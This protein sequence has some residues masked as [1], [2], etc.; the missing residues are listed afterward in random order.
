MTDKP[1]SKINMIDVSKQEEKPLSEGI[2]AKIAP[3]QPDDEVYKLKVKR[4][5]PTLWSQE[6]SDRIC[7]EISLGKSLRTVCG[8]DENPKEDMPDIVTILRWLREK[9]EFRTQ[10]E[11]AKEES[12]DLLTE[13]MLDISDNDVVQGDDKSDSARVQQSRLRVD[14]RKWIASKLKPKRYGDKLDLTSN[15]EKLTGSVVVYKDMSQPNDSNP[16]S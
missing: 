13:E 16:R 5:R 11:R 8:T 10:Y 14:T 3:I 6:L 12:A 7:K 4:G 2:L 1:I 15:N 9:E